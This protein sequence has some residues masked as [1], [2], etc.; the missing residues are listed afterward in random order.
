LAKGDY[1]NVFQA[2]QKYPGDSRFAALNQQASM[3]SKALDQLKTLF[4][5]G[6]YSTFNDKIVGLSSNKSFQDINIQAK[7]EEQD[8]KAL[9]ALKKRETWA[10]LNAQVNQ[11]ESEKPSLFDKKS[12]REIRDWRDQNDPITRLDQQ[13]SA[14]E[15]WY[16][17]SKVNVIDPSTG[18]NAEGRRVGANAIVDDEFVTNLEKN[19]Q[20]YNK[21]TTERQQR[22]KK[23]HVAIARAFDR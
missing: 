18:K 6:E 5:N 8:L 21:L 11:L 12:F 4:P 23:L 19:F 17:I 2:A 22:I 1:L 16:G 14:C 10:S 7:Q 13:L 9:E 3:E 15:V 20:R